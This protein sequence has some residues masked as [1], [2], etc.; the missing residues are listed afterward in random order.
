MANTLAISNMTYDL[1]SVTTLKGPQGTYFGTSTTGGAIIFRPNKPTDEFEGYLQFGGGEFN[2]RSAQGM[3]NLP[4]SDIFQIRL[5]G[6]IVKRDGYVDNITANSQFADNLSGIGGGTGNGIEELGNLD[7]QSARLSIHFEPTDF[8]T[9]DTV[10]NYYSQDQTRVPEQVAY[11]R[12][13]YNY[14]TFLGFPVPVDW[15]GAGVGLLDKDEIALGRYPVW[16]KADNVDIANT[17]NW[18]VNDSVS[19]KN[20]ISYQDVQ[21]DA[22]D[23]NDATPFTVVQGVTT[24]D[25]QQLTE[26][27]SIDLSLMDGAFR[28][29]TGIFYSNKETESIN[30]F[31]LLALPLDLTFYEGI[32]FPDEVNAALGL[33][34]GSSMGEAVRGYF[35]LTANNVYQREFESKA[36]YSQFAFEVSDSTTV[37]FGARYTQD[38]GDYKQYARNAFPFIFGDPFNYYYSPELGICGAAVPSYDNFNASEC[39]GTRDLE[40]SATS[41]T[42]TIENRVT[43][44]TMIYG[45]LRKGYLVGGF[46]GNVAVR[47]GKVFEPEEVKDAEMGIKSDWDLF[48]R[49]I[50]TNFA[51]FMGQYEN[52]QRVQNSITEE[53]TTYVAVANAGASKFYGWDLDISYDITDFLRTN[54]SWNHVTV[55]YD[56]FELGLN[57]PAKDGAYV[58]LQGEQLSQTPEDI[59]SVSAT[60]DWPVADSV[61]YLS[62][63]FGWYWRDD[64]THHDAPTY[65]CELSLDGECRP[66]NILED[67][68]KYDVL[69]SYSIVNLTTQ[70]NNAMGSNFDVNLWVK[71][72]TDEEYQVYGSNQA[73]QFGYATYMYGTPREYGIDLR[74]NF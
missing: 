40:T 21:Q 50:R 37:T 73:L 13:G 14:N 26:E 6:E 49:P 55:T 48:G 59:V 36:I 20:V 61:G 29:K 64:T 35:P 51:F 22:S 58:D 11:L 10:I 52:Q 66:E 12:P 30:S 19:F 53:G 42:L 24:H 71:N 3:L 18:A 47:E 46:N 57:L 32:I 74:Y 34:P 67:F 56:N 60:I 65:D 41:Y 27:F 72:L 33:A 5:A 63:T 17:T 68:S 16:S 7:Y 31:D 9:N 25:T 2:H 39:S 15:A 70:W 69:D 28:N 43:D 1:A 23:D 45:T 38:T 4:V 62:T 44:F 8:L 54:V